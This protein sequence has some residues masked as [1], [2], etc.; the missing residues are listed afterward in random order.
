[1]R[2]RRVAGINVFRLTTQ[3]DSHNSI[4]FGWRRCGAYLRRNDQTYS[5]TSR[6]P[7]SVL[8][9]HARFEAQSCTGKRHYDDTVSMKAWRQ[10]YKTWACMSMF[11]S[12]DP[13]TAP[14][15][16]LRGV[17]QRVFSVGG[18]G[19]PEDL[20]TPPVVNKVY[21]CTSDQSAE[22]GGERPHK[23]KSPQTP[24]RTT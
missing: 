20:G 15:R 2:R 12:V 17:K 10:I 22:T 7:L 4:S 1:M 9:N 16:G 18:A 19:G 6:E 5:F 3:A 23:M 11:P 8:D 13:G 24:F 14:D 21:L